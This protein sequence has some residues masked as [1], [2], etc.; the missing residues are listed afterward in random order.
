MQSHKKIFKLFRSE[1]GASLLEY[2][3]MVALIAVGCIVATTALGDGIK[4]TLKLPKD[5]MEAAGS[6]QNGDTP[7]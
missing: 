4:H 5:A 7:G 2:S 1:R 6:V 3:L